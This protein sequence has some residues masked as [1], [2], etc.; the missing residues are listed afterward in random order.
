MSPIDLQAKFPELRPIQS[1][2]N[3]WSVLGCGPLFYGCRDYDEETGSFIQ[4]HCLCLVWIP[5]LA[6]GAYRVMETDEGPTILGRVPLS[7]LAQTFTALGIVLGVYC[8]WLA[9]AGFAKD[10]ERQIADA[11]KAVK[12]LTAHG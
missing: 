5:I 10:L 1:V 4:T 8:G 2:P 11:D 9:V 6:L 12:K 7:T 3:R